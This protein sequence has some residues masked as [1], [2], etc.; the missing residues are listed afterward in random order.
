M[1]CFNWMNGFVW[2]SKNI[3]LHRNA[4][5]HIQVMLI[6]KRSNIDLDLHSYGWCVFCLLALLLKWETSTLPRWK[7]ECLLAVLCSSQYFEN[8]M[9]TSNL[10]RWLSHCICFCSSTPLEVSFTIDIKCFKVTLGN[11]P[12]QHIKTL[13]RKQV[14]QVNTHI[15][16]P[17][18]Q[19]HHCFLFYHK[20]LFFPAMH[21]LQGSAPWRAGLKWTSRTSAML[22][23]PSMNLFDIISRNSYNMI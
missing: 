18:P 10:L 1:D 22:S 6:N 17:L 5:L 3:N 13:F 9:F 19:W 8:A 2:S 21:K 12:L 15:V 11:M 7:T 20:V 23:F 4:W 14:I 16:V